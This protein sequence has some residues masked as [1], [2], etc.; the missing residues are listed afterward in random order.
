MFLTTS[1]VVLIQL[2]NPLASAVKW[3]KL[4]YTP[5][6]GRESTE[7]I[8]TTESTA[9]SA[10]DISDP[11][12]GSA[13]SIMVKSP[14][15]IL[16]EALKTV[17]VD[18][19]PATV[20]KCHDTGSKGCCMHVLYKRTMSAIKKQNLSQ[21]F[22]TTM[23]LRWETYSAVPGTWATKDHGMDLKCRVW[24]GVDWNDRVEYETVLRVRCD[25]PYV[26][27]I[28]LFAHLRNG[29]YK[30]AGTT[31][32]CWLKPGPEDD[33]ASSGTNRKASLS[34]NSEVITISH[35]PA[36]LYGGMLCIE[37]YRE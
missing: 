12:S 37:S 20:K 27:D 6:D 25:D 33:G 1:S 9:A 8:A 23:Y 26:T 32:F 22:I 7:M 28:S 29:R 5:A 17:Q 3:G 24:Y 14:R 30:A 36:T 15:E 19:S 2:L 16:I 11:R 21:S 34:P 13:S 10:S 18:D 35:T 31:G 4:T